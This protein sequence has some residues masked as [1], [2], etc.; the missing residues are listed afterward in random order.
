MAVIHLVD[1]ER[2][3]VGKS[4]FCRLLVEFFLEHE[5]DFELV[6]AD[7]FNPDVGRVYFPEHYSHQGNNSGNIRVAKELGRQIYFSDHESEVDKVDAIFEKAKH[8]DVIVNLPPQVGFLVD[9]WIIDND[10]LSLGLEYDVS[11]VK[12]FLYTGE[13]NARELFKQSLNH[14]QQGMEHVLVKNEAFCNNWSHLERDREIQS[15]LR[16]GKMKQT[17]L[18][19]LVLGEWES[20]RE[21]CLPFREAVKMQSGLT[22]ISRSRIWNF[23]KDVN[24]GIEATGI[25]ERRS[26]RSRKVAE[27]G[28][29]KGEIDLKALF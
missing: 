10:L 2:G 12:W 11:F 1:G 18:P 19:R 8:R 23:Q 7:R 29:I 9:S 28:E 15:Y 14:Y 4:I 17:R 16:E 3:G 27:I 21:R 22:V 26:Q 13:K 5:W 24:E 25:L 6:D 20:V